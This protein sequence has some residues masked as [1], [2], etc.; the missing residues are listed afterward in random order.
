MDLANLYTPHEPQ[1]GPSTAPRQSGTTLKVKL[2]PLN[3][4]AS[5]SPVNTP[6]LPTSYEAVMR[7]EDAGGP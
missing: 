3:G 5:A 2:K 6:G 4:S 7:P 1:A